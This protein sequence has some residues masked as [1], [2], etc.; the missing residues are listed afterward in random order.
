MTEDQTEG[1]FIIYMGIVQTLVVGGSLLLWLCKR[2]PLKVLGLSILLLG[3][4]A[5]IKFDAILQLAY[6]RGLFAYLP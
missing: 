5:A 3:I 4:V 2:R 6:E 1:A